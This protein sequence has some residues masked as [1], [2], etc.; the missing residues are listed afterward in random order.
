MLRDETLEDKVQKRLREA[1]RNIL[2][3]IPQI[4]GGMKDVLEEVGQWDDEKLFAE[5][6]FVEMNGVD[7]IVRLSGDSC[8]DFDHALVLYDWASKN[9]REFD[10][11]FLTNLFA[12]TNDNESITI[13]LRIWFL[14]LRIRNEI[15]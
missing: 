6:V 9:F 5:R 15:H 14:Y 8:K 1:G 11:E 2:Q 7:A 4:L 3:G 12:L 13:L 10:P